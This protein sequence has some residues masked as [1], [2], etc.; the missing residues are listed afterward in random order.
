MNVTITDYSPPVAVCDAYTVSSLLTDGLSM[1]YAT[2][3]DD[4]SFDN[5]ALDYL[6]VSRDG[7]NFSDF[8]VLGCV[9]LEVDSV[10]VVLRV[11]DVIGNFNECS[12]TV[13]VEDKLAPQI[14]CPL[15]KTIH[16]SDD[17]LNL[18]ITGQAIATENCTL[19]TIYFSDEINLNSC[20]IGT[21]SRTWVA[22]DKTGN[23]TSCTQ[24]IHLE[25]TTSLVIDFP[26]YIDLNGCES[27]T[28]PDITGEPVFTNNDCES[29]GV[30]FNDIVFNNSPDF[31]LKILRTWTVIDWCHYI[32][33]DPSGGGSWEYTQVIK[34]LDVEPSL[35]SVAGVIATENGIP[36]QDVNV[37]LV[38]SQAHTNATTEVGIYN[39]EGI[40]VIPSFTVTPSKDGDDMIG[41]TTIDMVF[42]QRHIL[43]VKE[44]DSPYQ[45]I[46]GDVNRSGSITT[47]DMVIMRQLILQIFRNSLQIPPGGL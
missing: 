15:D 16:C 12:A 31:C 6:K 46:A 18:N 9:D 33:N 38:A 22:K 17:F 39:F 26:E 27:S 25:D 19:D 44:L 11:Y 37:L 7:V 10:D 5:C 32:P 3:F 45:M 36:I 23:I 47:F 8:I 41:I 4:G 14:V 43:G 1:V 35:V 21:I 30:T 42:L 2:T 29:V 24:F 13:F 20:T 40:S 34:V 28:T